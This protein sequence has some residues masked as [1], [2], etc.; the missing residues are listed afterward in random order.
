MGTFG[1]DSSNVCKQKIATVTF[2]TY[3]RS[4]RVNYVL[5]TMTAVFVYIQSNQRYLQNAQT[6]RAAKSAHFKIPKKYGKLSKN[7]RK[8][9]LNL[10]E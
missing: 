9:F 3:A 6:H 1:Q 10:Q 7:T 4:N 2:D 5:N 8:Q